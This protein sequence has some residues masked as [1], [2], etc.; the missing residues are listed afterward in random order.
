[1]RALNLG[2]EEWDSNPRMSCPINGFQDRRLRPLGHPP[3]WEPIGSNGSSVARTRPLTGRQLRPLFAGPWLS[4]P[5]GLLTAR[6]KRLPSPKCGSRSREPDPE[7][8]RY[9]PYRGEVFQNRRREAEHGISRFS[10]RRHPA[11]TPG[12]AGRPVRGPV[13][14][15]PWAQIRT[16]DPAA[17]KSLR[18]QGGP[19]LARLTAYPGVCRGLQGSRSGAL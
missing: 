11:R 14:I 7:I 15:R 5:P 4:I 6:S 13:P 2:R 9:V 18:S 19:G 12:S 10:P 17:G 1:M 16:I 3:R 8:E